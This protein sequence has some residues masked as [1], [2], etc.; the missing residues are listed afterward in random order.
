MYNFRSV[1]QGCGLAEIDGKILKYPIFRWLTYGGFAQKNIF[2]SFIATAALIVYYK[3]A[4]HR[5]N[6]RIRDLCT[7]ANGAFLTFVSASLSSL[8]TI[9]GLISGFLCLCAILRSS[10]RTTING[11]L[12]AVVFDRY[13]GGLQLGPNVTAE[14]SSRLM[15]DKL[16]PRLQFACRL[17]FRI[18]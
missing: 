17:S 3:S 10:G 5:D 14:P 15:V 9:L 6:Y 8:T 13:F 7:L 2:G 18:C 4:V 11:Y 16:S 1:P 12:H